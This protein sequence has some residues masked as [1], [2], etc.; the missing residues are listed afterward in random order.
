MKPVPAIIAS[1]AV[2]FP[3]PASTQTFAEAARA[4]L[5]L[6]VELCLRPGTANQ[7]RVANFRAAGFAEQV[8]SSLGD[9]VHHFSAPA[10]TVKAEFYYG[11]MPE[12][13]TVTSNHVGVTDAS[14]I[15]DRIVPQL[16][17]GYIRN[18][19]QGPL[20]STTGRAAICVSYQQPNSPI[21]HVIGV[22]AAR[23][24]DTCTDDGTSRIY[25]VTL[26]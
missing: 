17:P 10:D 3:G 5:A 25:D 7:Q 23:T 4:N 26:V 11:Q 20:S 15:L 22:T 14:A 8:E 6:A 9:T 18:V 24:A 1:V 21:P 12:E 2:L 16:Y 19:V 13:C